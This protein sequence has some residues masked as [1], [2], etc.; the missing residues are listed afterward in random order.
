MLEMSDLQIGEF[1]EHL[2]TRS[3]CDGWWSAPPAKHYLPDTD[4]PGQN[5]G[6]LDGK[7]KAFRNEGV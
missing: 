5:K 2:L 3:L 1:G 6:C 7:S 4:I